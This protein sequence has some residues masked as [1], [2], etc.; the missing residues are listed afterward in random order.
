MLLTS[1]L[2]KSLSDYATEMLTAIFQYLDFSEIVKAGV[3]LDKYQTLWSYVKNVQNGVKSIAISILILFF[4]LALLDDATNER[5]SL[6]RFVKIFAKLFIG[7]GLIGYSSDIFQFACDFPL[8]FA[9]AIGSTGAITP[10]NVNPDMGAMNLVETLFAA[11]LCFIIGQV[12]GIVLQV[13]MWLV[14]FTRLLELMVRGAFLPIALALLGDDGWHGAAGRYFKKLIALG[15][16][17]PALLM[18]NRGYQ[19]IMTDLASNISNYNWGTGILAS[20]GVIIPALAVSL[21]CIG[22]C[23][24]SINIINDVFG[25]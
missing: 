2:Q 6:E 16:Q 7:F 14:C 5:F 18:I 13:I 23:K 19:V 1:T 21:A 17:G 10:M 11:L 12:L 8:D 15:V 22:L 9:D 20:V 24:Q 25:V 3:R 4:L